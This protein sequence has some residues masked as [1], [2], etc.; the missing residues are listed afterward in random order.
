MTV[1]GR[2]NSAM[3]KLKQQ[4]VSISIDDFGTGYSS[5]SYLSKPLPAADIEEFSIR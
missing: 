4:G 5:L 3:D 2:W 1:P